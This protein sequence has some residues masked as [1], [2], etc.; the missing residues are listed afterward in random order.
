MGEIRQKAEGYNI[1]NDRIDGMNLMTVY[2]AAKEKLELIR[3]GGGP[4]FL[5]ILTYRYR[6]HS[7]GDPERYRKPEESQEVARK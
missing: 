1:P 6:G 2:E 5:E 7:M 4:Y 3:G